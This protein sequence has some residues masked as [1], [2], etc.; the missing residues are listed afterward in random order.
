MASTIPP[1]SK[2]PL[3]ARSH[4][5]ARSR[6]NWRS[7]RPRS[8]RTRC[9]RARWRWRR[10]R[11]RSPTA[12]AARRPASS[13]RGRQRTGRGR[14]GRERRG[15]IG[16][17]RQRG[18]DGCPHTRAI[19]AATARTVRGMMLD[20]VRFGTGTAAAIPGVEVAGKTG[21][22]ELS[23]P[24]A[25]DASSEQKPSRRRRTLI[26]LRTHLRIEQLR[27]RTEQP[28]EHRRVVCGVRPGA[29]P[30]DRGGGADGARR[31]GR[32]KRGAGGAAGDRSGAA[33]RRLS[34]ADDAAGSRGR[35]R[36]TG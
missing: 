17:E 18:R 9:W 24:A 13:A 15:Q 33:G 36:T 26:L 11:R 29:A 19:S 2:A 12:G 6:A 4:R 10:W 1:G 7:A 3:K 22:A 16:G 20:V 30:E 21:T 34:G 14:T 32:R 35:R 5:P 27:G 25:C 23:T 8:A 28:E 31:R